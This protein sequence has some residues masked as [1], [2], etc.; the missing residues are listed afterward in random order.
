MPSSAFPGSTQSL[1]SREF[2]LLSSVTLNWNKQGLPV[3]LVRTMGISLSDWLR[4][5]SL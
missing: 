4:V 3:G 1:V 2:V 5:M